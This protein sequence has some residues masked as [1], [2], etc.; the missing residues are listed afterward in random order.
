[1]RSKRERVRRSDCLNVECALVLFSFNVKKTRTKGTDVIIIGALFRE[2][3]EAVIK[4]F[5]SWASVTFHRPKYQT[6]QNY[7]T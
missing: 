5:L 7:V 4:D 1:M 2:N 6:Y 3:V